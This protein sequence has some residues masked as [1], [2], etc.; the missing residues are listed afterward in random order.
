MNA[1]MV[2]PRCWILDEAGCSSMTGV[3]RAHPAVAQDACKKNVIFATQSLADIKD[4]SIA[5]VIIGKLCKLHLPA[6]PAGD[7][8]ADLHDSRASASIA[9]D[10]DNATA[11]PMYALTTTTNP[12]FG[13]RLYFDLDLG[14]AALA[15]QGASTPQD[16]RH[17]PRAAGRRHAWSH[18]R[19]AAPSRPRLGG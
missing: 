19:S 8:A 4:S 1:L 17:R 12:A 16:Q 9:A 7:R 14:P 6:E 5:P 2:R 10:R 13:N 3:C 11:Q 18:G 15:F